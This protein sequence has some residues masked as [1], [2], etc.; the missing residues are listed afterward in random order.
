[1]QSLANFNREQQSVAAG[2]K[3]MRDSRLAKS[4]AR[5]ARQLTAVQSDEEYQRLKIA[6]DQAHSAMVAAGGSWYTPN[7]TSEQA[8][9]IAASRDAA[10]SL[11]A[12]I[13]QVEAST[14]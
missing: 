5:A 11:T 6:A 14:K 8:L 4:R 2:A 13:R 10:A 9:L 1:M 12:R 7:P 3:E